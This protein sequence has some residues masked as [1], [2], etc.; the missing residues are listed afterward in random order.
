MLFYYHLLSQVDA[1][2][3]KLFKQQ[4]EYFFYLHFNNKIDN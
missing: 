1:F 2:Q 3:D 4:N